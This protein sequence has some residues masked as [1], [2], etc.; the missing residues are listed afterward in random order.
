MPTVLRKD[1][2]KFFFYA[3]EHLPLHI[4]I[5]KGND[6]AKINIETLEIIVNYFKSN[7]LNKIINII[8][9]NQSLLMEK[10]NE[11]FQR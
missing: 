10:W 9:E 11:C 4:H 2:F 5:T 6:F 3:N 7:E 1:G 8:K